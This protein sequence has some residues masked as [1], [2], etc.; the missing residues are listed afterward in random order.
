MS[1]QPDT[2]V[3]EG[4]IYEKLMGQT[5]DET[6]KEIIRKLLTIVSITI[7]LDDKMRD[8]RKHAELA[9]EMKNAMV[10]DIYLRKV[11]SIL[12]EAIGQK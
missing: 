2:S 3:L 11:V 5:I 1:E 8:A 9:L 4:A 10:K 12:D 7:D 6:D